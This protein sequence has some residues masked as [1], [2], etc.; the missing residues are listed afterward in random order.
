MTTLAERVLD[1]LQESLGLSDRELTDRLAGKSAG[2]Q[3]VNQVARALAARGRLNRR[4]RPDGRIGNYPS[5][6]S[7]PRPAPPP[8]LPSTGSPKEAGLSEDDVKRRL[9]SWLE[10]AGW[11]VEVKWGHD[12]GIDVVAKRGA[13]TWLIEAKGCG[14]REPMRV[15]YF[16]VLLGE[17]LQRMEYPTARY[18]I[19]LPDMKQYRG[20]WDRLPQLAKSRTGVSA[21]FVGA[22][23]EVIE[24]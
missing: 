13:E 5:D 22:D 17:T 10:A 1:A 3:A 6:F 9:K 7:P 14:S 24:A 19:A 18:S 4:R 20:L 16:L 11:Q 12:H 2:Q 21:L 23:G 15:N 8:A